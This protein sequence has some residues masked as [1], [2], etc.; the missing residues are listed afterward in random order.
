MQLCQ[1]WGRG[2][3][4]LR[5]LQYTDCLSSF[6]TEFG[7]RYVGPFSFHAAWLRAGTRPFADDYS[8]ARNWLAK[9]ELMTAAGKID[10]I[11]LD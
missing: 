2:F 1:G 7:C 8:Y 3:E 5:P 9:E 4:S 6:A 11:L 10:E